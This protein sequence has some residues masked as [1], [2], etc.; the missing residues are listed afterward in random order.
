M[1]LDRSLRSVDADGH[2][3][4]E[5]SRISKANICPYLGREIPDWQRLGLNPD[6]TYRLFRDPKEL[7]KGAST[8]DGKPLLVR[9]VPID[10]D[11]PRKELWVGT[12]GRTTWEEPY[13]IT[14]PLMVLTNEAIDLIEKGDRGEPDGQRE[15]SA[16]YRYDA[17]MEPGTWGGQSYDGRMVNIRGNH[18]AIVSEGRVGPDVHVAD[19]QPP[20]FRRMRTAAAAVAEALKP[21]LGT[22]PNAKRIAIALDAMLGETPAESVISLDAEEMKACEDEALAEKR[23]EQGEDAELDDEEREKAYERARDKKRAKDK[24]ARDKRAKD[25][26]A[27]DARARDHARDRARDHA[28]DAALDAREASMDAREEAE[29]EGKEDEEVEDRRKARDARRRARDK[30]ARD[31]KRAHD[32][33][34]MNY[35]HVG[36]EDEEVDHRE[37]FEP[38]KAKDGVTKDEM[39]EAVKSA[40]EAERIRSRQ[41]AEAREK[42]RPLVGAVS[43][44]MDSAEA[45]YKFALKQTGVKHEGVH[46]SALGAL[47][48]MAVTQARSRSAGDSSIAMDAATESLTDLDAIFRPQPAKAA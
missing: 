2:M 4:V 48:D 38:L 1:A 30:R 18:V 14:R 3:R 36:G 12:V 33:S 47:V 5:E 41:A 39:T 40:V 13:L 43:M 11:L 8:F 31:R 24:R 17:V 21:F 7:E 27:E 19:E 44:A 45:I 37:D 10:A 22:N 42:V 16:A 28:R 35:G 26:A 34:A 20:E 23:K 9:H 6:R 29:D 25:K 32:V 15:L 46:P